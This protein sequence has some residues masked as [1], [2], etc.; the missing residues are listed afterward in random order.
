[1]E[2]INGKVSGI[3]DS[4]GRDTDKQLDHRLYLSEMTWPELEKYLKSLQKKELTLKY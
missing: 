2:Y 3:R 4:G 1:M